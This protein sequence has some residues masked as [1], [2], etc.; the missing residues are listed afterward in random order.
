MDELPA[1]W[2]ILQEKYT[3][4]DDCG[5]MYTFFTVVD[6][7]A[8]MGSCILQVPSS[9]ESEKWF[10][11]N[12]QF[13]SLWT[14]MQ[15]RSSFWGVRV[16]TSLVMKRGCSLFAIK[17]R[18]GHPRKQMNSVAEVELLSRLGV[19]L[20]P[21][22]PIGELFR[23]FPAPDGWGGHRLEPDL[24]LYGMLKAEGA[25]LFVE[26]DGY[27]RHA[28]RDGVE[29]DQMKNEAL[30]KYSPVG[31]QVIRI[32]HT[33][34]E[35]VDNVV[36][37]KID[38][39]HRGHQKSL[40]EIL[41]DLLLQT[42]HALQGLLDE[43]VVNRLT[44]LINRKVFQISDQAESF[45]HAAVVVGTGNTTEEIHDFLVS[46]GF[47][48]KLVQTML[49]SV[50]PGMSIERNLKPKFQWLLGLGLTKSQVAK[51]VARFP[52]IL[53]FSI[54][55]NLKPT[56][57]WL[58]DL[59]LTNIQVAKVV[60]GFPPILG[61]SIEQNLK[62]TVRWLLVL[63]LTDSQVAKVVA[64]FPSILGFSIEHNLKP[65]VQW[66]LDLGL[67]NIQVAKVVAGF[68]PILGCS[69]E[70]NLKPTVQWLLDLGLTHNQVAKTVAV[71]PAILGYSFERNLERKVCFLR[72][73][74]TERGCADLIARFPQVLGYKYERLTTRVTFLEKINATN[75]IWQVMT[76]ADDK[77]LRW[78]GK[79]L[80][81][82]IRLRPEWSSSIGLAFVQ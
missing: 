62:P 82:W 36:W 12:T 40:S 7:R 75:K 14:Q 54:E 43:R 56:V 4:F 22:V 50:P 28:E 34:S 61:C 3:V 13:R 68:P 38:T 65:T 59:G 47:G 44:F 58:L 21:Q 37:I 78:V 72:G 9:F 10:A 35:R 11:P 63:G 81:G 26:Y 17:T 5:R 71:F 24:A 52:P 49:S 77:Y 6:N 67:T 53:G 1:E 73:V 2:R 19:L 39:W 64:G 70:Q 76:F 42:G 16:W 66:L 51:T 41:M 48:H 32:S 27:W 29:R 79:Q 23:S 15:C 55:H 31:S 25:A 45:A 69:I 74:L 33:L 46:E 57:Q 20:K 60:A 80:H 30:L 8:N 18:E